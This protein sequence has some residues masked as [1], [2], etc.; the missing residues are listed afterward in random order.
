MKPLQSLV[1]LVLLCVV[2]G[3]SVADEIVGNYEL[4]I[5]KSACSF[6]HPQAVIAKGVVVLSPVPLTGGVAAKL[7]HSPFVKPNDVR[8][9]FFGTPSKGAKSFAFLTNAMATS[10]ALRGNSLTFELFR[11]A[12]AGYEV[13]LQRKG[14]VFVG[15]GT[16]W[17]AGV[18]APHYSP[19]TVLARRI[20]PV[21]ISACLHPAT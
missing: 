8:A 16:S 12:D 6:E 18:A 20:G 15:N 10:W 9:C 1:L 7:E 13:E 2:S 21:N 19:D 14:N 5:C 17:G 11:S 4:L 3:C